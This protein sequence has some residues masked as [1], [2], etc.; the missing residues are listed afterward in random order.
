MSNQSNGNKRGDFL[1]SLIG[2]RTPSKTAGLSY[3]VLACFTL[4]ASLLFTVFAG[5]AASS[6]T[7]PQWYLYLNFLLMPVVLLFVG[8]WYFSYTKTPLSTFVKEQRCHPKYYL[9]AV[10]MQLGMLWLGELNTLFLGFL[11]RFGYQNVDILLPS[12]DGFGFVGVFFAVA[13]L[14]SIMEEFFFRGILL[15]ESK[16]FPFWSSVL[17]CG[18]L[19]SLFH[20]NPAQTI[21]QFICGVAF[22]LVAVRAGSFLPSVL[23]HFINNGVIVV[24]Y[25]LGIT[26][27]PKP[28]YIT[29]VTVSVVCLA[30]ALVY[31]FVFDKPKAKEG[32]KGSY[33]EFFTCASVGL[34]V[35]GL[36][37][38]S[39]LLM[40][41]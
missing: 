34:G 35:F 26:S 7:P 2:D 12:V 11:E 15:R 6:E 36:T 14:P 31:L 10:L 41:F 18:G 13:V 39:V 19:F 25:K 23:A 5:N 16:G 32:G 1:T 4:V 21:Y 27:Y 3:S 24:L 20:Q 28:V 30:A 40:G 29:L 8:G 9:I 38:L 37:W 17:L 33:K 22:A